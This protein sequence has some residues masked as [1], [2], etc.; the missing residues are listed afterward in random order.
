VVLLSVAGSMCLIIAAMMIRAKRER[1]E[2][3]PADD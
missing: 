3:A 2:L 1:K